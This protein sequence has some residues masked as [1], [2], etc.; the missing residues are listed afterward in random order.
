MTLKQKVKFISIWRSFCLSSWIWKHF[1]FPAV[2]TRIHSTR[3][4]M[5]AKA[6]SG[7]THVQCRPSTDG[8]YIVR[9]YASLS[10]QIQF[11]SGKEMWNSF[12][13]RSLFHMSAFCWLSFWLCWGFDYILTLL[14]CLTE[15]FAAI[16]NIFLPYIS[17]RSI[18]FQTSVFR[19]NKCFSWAWQYLTNL[20][21]KNS[22]NLILRPCK[23]WSKPKCKMILLEYDCCVWLENDPSCL[24]AK[25]FS[26]FCHFISLQIQMQAWM[27][28]HAQ[29]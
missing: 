4:Q 27:H 12:A 14:G 26:T 23:I 16:Q 18:F 2:C 11:Q 29:R 20:A 13:G 21:S 25:H 17:V 1:A 8:I 9:K 10:T 3:R 15:Y 28:K 5:T 19:G 6:S 24:K 7:Y 22:S